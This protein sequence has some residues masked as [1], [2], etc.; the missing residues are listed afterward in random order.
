MWPH[1]E[2]Y[3]FIVVNFGFW[4][5]CKTLEEAHQ[6]QRTMQGD[7]PSIYT[8]GF[9]SEKFG[10]VIGKDRWFLLERTY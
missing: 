2:G 5:L 1:K 3:D 8:R 7:R 9:Y 6:V 10:K 4:H